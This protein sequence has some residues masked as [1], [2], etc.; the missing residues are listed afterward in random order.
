MKQK[1]EEQRTSVVKPLEIIPE[2]TDMT[3]PATMDRSTE[4]LMGDTYENS[5]PTQG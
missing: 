5:T 1:A 4:N 3:T 2:E